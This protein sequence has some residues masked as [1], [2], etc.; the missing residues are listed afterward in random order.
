M[1]LGDHPNAR[2]IVKPTS[3]QWVSETRRIER[4]TYIAK[5]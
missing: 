4:Q 5:A 1:N 3:F 2:K